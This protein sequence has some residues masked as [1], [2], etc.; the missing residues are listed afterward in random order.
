MRRCD[1]NRRH[2]EVGHRRLGRRG[3]DGGMR[4]DDA[5]GSV[6]PRIRDTP[7]ADAAVVVGHVLQQPLDRVVGVG[8]LVDVGVRL[9][10]VDVRPHLDEIAF[11]Q[12]TPADVLKHEDVAGLV[13]RLRRSQP[14]PELI[15]AVRRHAVRRA[16]HQE[17]I[18]PRGVLR[19]VD[20]REEPLAVAHR[21]GRLVLRVVLRDAEGWWLREQH[22]RQESDRWNQQYCPLHHA[23]PPRRSASASNFNASS[24]SGPISG[25]SS[26]VTTTMPPSVTVWRRRSSSML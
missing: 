18:A 25:S 4:I 26:V 17:R 6:E 19:H 24:L 12:I 2:E 13:E 15:D 16:R 3:F 8:A 22:G 20:R 9:R 23:P 5:R 10:L 7:D 1:T 14:R 21:D 11:R